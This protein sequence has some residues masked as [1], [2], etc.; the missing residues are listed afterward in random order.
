MNVFGLVLGSLRLPRWPSR[1]WLALIPATVFALAVAIEQSTRVQAWVLKPGKN[2]SELG[3]V[4][5]ALE[6]AS[7]VGFVV[8]LYLSR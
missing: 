8:I 3:P 6:I 2:V 1:G 4:L 5:G 7:A